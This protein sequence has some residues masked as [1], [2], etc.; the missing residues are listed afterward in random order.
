MD[1][2]DAIRTVLA[3]RKFRDTPIPEE[4]VR[5]I[6]EAGRL[7]ASSINGQP[8][9]FIVVQNKETLRQLGVL[10]H[11][12]PISPQAPLAIVGRHGRKPLRPPTPAVPFSR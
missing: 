10:A 11:L 8:W 1:T 5:R 3:V 2:F 7:T 9:H 6:V 4:T 12:D